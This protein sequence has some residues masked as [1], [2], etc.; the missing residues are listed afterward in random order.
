MN[1]TL[2]AALE[3]WVANHPEEE[4]REPYIFSGKDT[5]TMQ[6]VLEEVRNQTEVG[7]HFE[8]MLYTLTID[9]ISRG[10]EKL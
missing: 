5:Y 8:L 9:L 7:I 2:L 1:T 3:R 10:K 6:G 4:Q